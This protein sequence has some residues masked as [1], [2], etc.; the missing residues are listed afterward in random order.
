LSDEKETILDPDGFITIKKKPSREEI[1][2]HYSNLYVNYKDKKIRKNYQEEYDAKE[3]QHI[4]LLNDLCLYS[5]TK[6]RNNWKENPGSFFEVGV[7]EGFLLERARSNG[8]NIQG[9]DF[10]KFGIEKFNP[11]LIDSV[12]FGDAFEMIEK[13]RKVGKRYDVCVIQN[14]LEHVLEPKTLLFNL[15]DLLTENGIIVI[16]VPNDFSRVQRRAYD[17]GIVKEKFWI[18]PPEH[19]NYFNTENISIFLENLDFKVLDTYA[20]FPIDFF[21]F[22]KGSNYV[23]NEKNGKD[24]H[25][26]RIELDLIMAEG[27]IENYHRLC[28]SLILCNVGRS[29][30][31]IIE[32]KK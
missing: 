17:L 27:G 12:E 1:E 22:H 9:I 28:Q 20:S 15:K 5:I 4:N 3:I 16:K 29:L 32:K 2:K 26:A 18:V 23:I 10:N 21:L 6:I 11:Q 24:A 19:L 13:Y 14:I 30:T 7:G 25:K 31:I 8:W